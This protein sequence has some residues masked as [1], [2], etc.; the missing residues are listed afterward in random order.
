MI[1]RDKG[2]DVK[3]Q[4]TSVKPGYAVFQIAKAFTT[5]EEHEDL[6]TRERAKEKVSKWEGIL[7]GVLTG[8]ALIANDASTYQGITKKPE[9]LR[10]LGWSNSGHWLMPDVQR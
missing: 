3:V 2:A 8:L 1:K 5:S 9:N 7:R 4:A 6:E 10:F